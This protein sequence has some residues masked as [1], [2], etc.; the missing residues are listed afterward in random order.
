MSKISHIL[1]AAGTSKR[2]GEPKQLLPWGSQ[3]LIQFQVE[4]ILP[5][6]EHLYVVLG[7]Y[8]DRVEPLLKGLDVESIRCKHW[9]KG[10][11]AS[12]SFVINEILNT[13]SDLDGVLVSLID[14]PLVSSAHYLKMRALFQKGNNQIIV[15]ESDSG[16]CGVPVL[17]DSCYFHDLKSLS[18][19]EGAKVIFKRNLENVVYVKSGNSLVDMDTPE[20]YQ[21][22]LKEFSPQ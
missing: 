15:S 4:K 19:E 21:K 12:L 9:E 10:M 7:A 18:G 14:Q 11:G 13:N 3:S 5:T 1:L 22:L 8:A 2:M 16:W 6:T 17:F 20:M